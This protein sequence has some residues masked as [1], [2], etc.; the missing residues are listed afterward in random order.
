MLSV[1]V[2]GGHAQGFTFTGFVAGAFGLR[3]SYV[4]V[5]SWPALLAIVEFLFAPTPPTLSCMW[6]GKN[7]HS[8]I[9]V[10][11]PSG[12]HS[13]GCH[14]YPTRL[15]RGVS[16]ATHGLSLCCSDSTE[17]IHK[18]MSL[19]L[20]RERT[21]EPSKIQCQIEIDWNSVHQQWS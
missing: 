14:G 10:M 13:Q 5:H 18:G 17:T 1:V 6:L 11:V 12:C 15:A 3:S 2:R 16:M 4:F 9:S 19:I 8:F 7:F 21:R 20:M